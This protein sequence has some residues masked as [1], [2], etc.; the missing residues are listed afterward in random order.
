MAKTKLVIDAETRK[1]LMGYSVI[2]TTTDFTPS[3]EGVDPSLLPTFRIKPLNVED[4]RTL[5]FLF[6]DAMNDKSNISTKE[7]TK[8]DDTL[9]KITCESIVGY[10]NLIDISTDTCVDWNPEPGKEHIGIDF[11]GSLPT[12]LKVHI[13]NHILSA[14]GLA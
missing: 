9:N 14:N 1:K 3:I 10:D 8:R 6:L 4:Q 12:M 11:Y 5:K 7:K 2:S 13:M